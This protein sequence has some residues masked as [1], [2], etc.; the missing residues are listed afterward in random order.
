MSPRSLHEAMG[1][2]L[3]V[4]AVST[5]VFTRAGKLCLSIYLCISLSM[6]IYVYLS[7]SLSMPL[8]LVLCIKQWDKDWTCLR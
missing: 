3:D 5:A 1:K 7:I 2:R 4:L 6:S 8:P